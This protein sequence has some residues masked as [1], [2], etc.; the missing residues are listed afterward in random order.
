MLKH[1]PKALE[2]DA[3]VLLLNPAFEKSSKPYPGRI[4]QYPRGVRENGAQY[5][6]GCSWLVDSA[7]KLAGMLEEQGKASSAKAW[8]DRAGVVWHKI[9]PL[10]HT[11]PERW[12]NYGLEP[13]QQAADVYFGPGYEGRGGWS[14][15]TGSAARMLTA[16]R[17]LLG[18]E[19]REGQLHIAD[20]A[21][22]GDVWPH[23]QSVEW[24]GE[25]INITG[26][27][28]TQSQ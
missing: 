26:P 19:F 5:S 12:L 17:D 13:Y 8:R 3:L 21:K 11:T 20:W 6:H 2:R 1:G 23:L 7:L 28:Q 9:S 18:L 15:Y 4:A 14:W 25:I 22:K 10:A 16:A 24:R 27:E